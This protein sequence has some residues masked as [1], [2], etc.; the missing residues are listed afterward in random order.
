MR[1]VDAL[2]RRYNSYGAKDLKLTGAERLEGGVVVN[3]DARTVTKNGTEI[4]LRDKEIDV[5]MYLVTNRGRTV[6]PYELYEAVW[7]EIPLPS[8]NNNVT[9]HILNLRRRLEDNPSSPKIIRTVWGKGYQ[10]D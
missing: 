6:A 3:V 9:V 1:K 7:G 10:I 5:L 4:D 2:T 8:S